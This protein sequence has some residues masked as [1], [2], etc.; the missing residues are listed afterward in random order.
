MERGQELL[1]SCLSFENGRG[2]TWGVIIFM[3]IIL[4][5]A[6]KMM[7]VSKAVQYERVFPNVLAE[8]QKISKPPEICAV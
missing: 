7:K 4:K 1:T 3:R 2:D 8:A 5:I 6:G